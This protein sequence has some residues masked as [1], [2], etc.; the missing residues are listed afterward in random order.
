MSDPAGCTHERR[1][2][3][4][5]P[6][7]IVGRARAR[8]L[9]ARSAA[10]CAGCERVAA[11]VAARCDPGRGAGRDPRRGRVANGGAEPSL[12]DR[13]LDFWSWLA[14]PPVAAGFASVMAATLVGMLWWDRPMDET[15]LP[16]PSSPAATAPKRRGERRPRPAE[17]QSPRGGRGQ[18]GRTA[19]GSPAGVGP[20]ARRTCTRTRAARRD[21]GGG[22]DRAVANRCRARRRWR[23]H[24]SRRSR[25]RP[26][27]SASARRRTRSRR[28]GPKRPRPNA[29]TTGSRAPPRPRSRWRRQP[30]R[31]R[32]PP[33]APFVRRARRRRRSRRARRP[34]P[35][36]RPRQATPMA[37]TPAPR[38]GEHAAARS[39]ARP[40]RALR[41]GEE[42]GVRRKGKR[43]RQGP[44]GRADARVA[45]TRRRRTRRRGAR[46]QRSGR[47]RP[48][49]G[50]ERG[51]AGI[52]PAGRR[53]PPRPPDRWHPCSPP[54]R[55]RRRAGRGG[56]RTA[57]APPVDAALRAWLAQV[58]SAA[59]RWEAATERN[60]RRDAPAASSPTRDPAPR[61]RRPR[62][63]ARPDRGR[64]RALRP[65][66]RQRLVRALPPEVVAR[67]RA[68]LP[69]APR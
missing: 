30:A 33:R 58:Q 61:A 67:L 36:R 57:R 48:G 4:F 39:G 5:A 49:R 27:P 38:A 45:G 46:P 6:E 24:A 35:M 52:A 3:A 23:P 14:R 2:P 66:L 28:P 65:A 17:T 7:P 51:R 44:I 50:A 37:A 31:P 25:A 1:R 15:R 68:T 9:A 8:R 69:P 60:A 55:A 42:G 22:E 62:R 19:G 16:P 43:R 18:G 53:P 64:R 11:A 21:T 20:S 32:R 59:S 34:R 40:R 13:A 12:L 63:R 47:H 26:P 29:R 10:P 41:P 56:W 54:W